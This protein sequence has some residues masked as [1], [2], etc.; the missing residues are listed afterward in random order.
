[1]TVAIVCI[2]TEITR[3][4]LVNTNAQW[5]AQQVTETGHEVTH[6]ATVDDDRGRIVALLQHLGKDHKVV[7]CT[8]GL[9]PTSDDLT[10]E[11]A[12]LAAR[13]PLVRDPQALRAVC[14]WF[15]SHGRPMAPIN[16]RQ[17]DFP[18]GATVL[19]NDKGTA[20]G[21]CMPI[22]RALC[23]F[24]PGVPKE[25]QAMWYRHGEALLRKLACDPVHQIRLGCFGAG[26][27]DIAQRLEGVQQMFEGLTIAYRAS[28]PTV[29][30]KLM[31]RQTLGSDAR[32][33]L[34]RARAFVR[35]RLGDLVYGEGEVDMVHLLAG[36]M[37]RAGQT[38]ALAESC[39]GGLLSEL[40]TR[41]PASDYYLGSVVTYTNESKEKFLGVPGE[42]LQN[43][44]AVSEPVALAMAKGV[45][46]TLGA[47]VG[48]GI[49][50]IAGPSGGTEA[51]PVG[52]VYCA[53]ATS[54]GA[55]V[56]HG[57]IP[58]D[59]QRVQRYAAFRAMRLVIE[60]LQCFVTP[61]VTPGT[62][63][64]RVVETG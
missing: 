56:W 21:F 64:H 25:M 7:V 31:V 58:G 36:E 26:E 38:L 30:V 12:A 11:C 62:S 5:L 27:S 55:K 45:R 51:K 39:T 54:Q 10:S 40:V 3:G 42:L 41:E 49:T 47:S 63:L 34:Q 13:R 50:G 60:S 53:V 48:V 15:D 44:G 46:R 9:G 29:E 6:I 1:M 33:V 32:A 8:G 35:E 20:P 16:F 19:A 52:L 61:C 23:M 14:R 4:E 37:R 59:R 57:V 2:G 43:D 24:F 22:G 18:S 28:I 17:A